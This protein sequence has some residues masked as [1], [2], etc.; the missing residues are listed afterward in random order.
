[1]LDVIISAQSKTE[2]VAEFI[3]FLKAELST[4]SL[5]ARIPRLPVVIMARKDGARYLTEVMNL[6]LC[7]Y[8]ATFSLFAK[9]VTQ[10]F[11]YREEAMT[12]KARLDHT[13]CQ[14]GWAVFQ[15][16]PDGLS[17]RPSGL[18]E[19]IGQRSPRLAPAGAG[20]SNPFS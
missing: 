17:I 10:R 19:F 8:D 9:D 3:M 7:P 14:R 4:S 2:G 15:V 12:W 11:S 1:M 13:D 5:S 16:Y 20:A 18:G 6:E